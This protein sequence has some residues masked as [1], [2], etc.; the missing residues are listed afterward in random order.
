MI[1]EKRIL[2]SRHKTGLFTDKSMQQLNSIDIAQNIECDSSLPSY[3]SSIPSYNSSLPSDTN[4]NLIEG[5]DD[6]ELLST[7][8]Q[9]KLNMKIDVQPLE[10]V[11]KNILA[12]VRTIDLF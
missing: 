3:D 7:V 4:L 9:E 11:I 8:I 1:Q 6:V 12:Q 5:A 2:E 10:Q